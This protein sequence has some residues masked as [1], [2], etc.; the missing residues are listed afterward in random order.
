V[1]AVLETIRP[2]A[3][4][5]AVGALVASAAVVSFAAVFALLLGRLPLPWPI[6]IALAFGLT[7]IW[8]LT[9]IRYDA[10]VA[11]GFV[12]FSII[13]GDPAPT[14]A[15]F[16]VIIAIAAVTGRFHIDRLPLSITA[17]LGA[18]VALNAISMFD[19][20][21]LGVATRFALITVFL[22]IFAIWLTTYLDSRA[23]ARLVVRAYV[24]PAATFA[25]LATIALFVSFPGSDLLLRYDGTRA[26]GLFEDPNV[27]GPFLIPAALIVLDEILNPRLLSNGRAVKLI[28]F[29]SLSAGILF[30][31]SRAAWIS[32]AV[33]ILVFLAVLTIRRGGGRRAVA[34]IGVLTLVGCGTVGV[35][36]A[37]GSTEF[38]TER[39]QFQRY[40]VERF[41]AQRTG[42]EF[43]EKHPL[44]VGPGQFDVL[45]PVSTHST[46][47]RTLAEQGL[48]GLVAIAAILLATLVLAG[49]SAILGRDTYGIGSAALFAA[50]VGILINSFVVDTLHW[51]HLWFVAAL[52]WIG[53]MRTAWG[54]RP[55]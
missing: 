19:A 15:V 39:A 48:L 31:F 51:R 17:L 10:A 27:F 9:V 43:A 7:G 21:E 22:V 38:L 3:R 35:I 26:T 54:P 5:D 29:F 37:T 6:V 16:G 53:A 30:S 32:Y 45:V 13:V 18:F 44:G 34:L 2:I 46:Y 12:V 23:R 33:G 8:M 55:T 1:A 40:D 50:W 42:L 11:V 36:S 4:R 24:F 28:L 47:I 20:I 52:I 41:D 25:L 49:R 14:D